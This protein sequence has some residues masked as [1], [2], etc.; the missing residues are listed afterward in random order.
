MP[1]LMVICDY[2]KKTREANKMA[3][4]T[5]FQ[6]MR[7]IMAKLDYQL[8]KDAETAKKAKAKEKKNGKDGIGLDI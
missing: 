8:R 4:K 1:T 5:E 3:K 6:Q 2:R 7:S